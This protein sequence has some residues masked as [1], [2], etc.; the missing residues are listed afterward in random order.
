[1]S[2]ANVNPTKVFSWSSVASGSKK[3]S[4]AELE[5]ERAKV[6]AEEAK[7][8]AKVEAQERERKQQ[9]FEKYKQQELL[10]GLDREKQAREY[11][12][13]IAKQEK[14]IEECN[15]RENGCWV[16]LRTR[17]VVDDAQTI[18]RGWNCYRTLDVPKNVN[19]RAM[20]FIEQ[21]LVN[22]PEVATTCK[23]V[24]EF[25]QVFM[26]AYVGYALENYL[27]PTDVSTVTTR[28]EQY[29]EF[30]RWVA[31]EEAGYKKESAAFQRTRGGFVPTPPWVRNKKWVFGKNVN[32]ENCL[33]AMNVLSKTFEM[34]EPLGN[35]H[36]GFVQITGNPHID[37][38]KL[39][40]LNTDL[41][42]YK[43]IPHA[44]KEAC[45]QKQAK[46]AKEEEELRDYYN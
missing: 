36:T 25:K 38:S 18:K 32:F 34:E 1:M 23:T 4:N 6:K 21:M 40:W 30:Q 11:A 8:E 43:G 7:V 20:E 10:K 35:P 33:W 44:K 13:Q 22:Y 26:D 24:G 16:T 37:S 39:T 3:Q 17:Q 12:E 42:N 41:G 31:S 46:L 9:L 14:S 2:T 27:M 45:K 5:A 28:A 15:K 19:E 29:A